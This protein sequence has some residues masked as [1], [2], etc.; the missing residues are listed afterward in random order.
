[1]VFI[2][3][4]QIGEQMGSSAAQ[5]AGAHGSG[6]YGPL[7]LPKGLDLQGAGE[8]NQ[9]GCEKI[10]RLVMGKKPHNQQQKNFQQ[11][12]EMLPLEKVGPGFDPQKVGEEN[13]QKK[14]KNGNEIPQGIIQVPFQQPHSQQGH[15]AGLGIG[16]NTA[17][18]DKRIG[19]QYTAG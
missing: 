4:V 19:F 15:V 3:G 10:R 12:D 8:R 7:Y 14:G 11:Q 1:M 17:A 9:R 2:P 16:K 6:I 13:T 18:H 5:I